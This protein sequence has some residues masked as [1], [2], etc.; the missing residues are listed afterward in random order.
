MP[1]PREAPEPTPAQAP[2]PIPEFD[3]S[4]FNDTT[5]PGYIEKGE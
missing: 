4:P 3:S 1:D 5:D 2:A